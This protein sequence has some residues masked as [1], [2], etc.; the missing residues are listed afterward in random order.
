MTPNAEAA[1]K[2]RLEGNECFK[3]DRFHQA[4]EL[5]TKAIDITPTPNLLCN[6]SFAYIKVELPGAALMD[7]DE[8]IRLEPGFAKAYYRKASAHL[9]M[10]KFKEALADFEIVRK[11]VPTDEDA[12]KKWEECDKKVRQIRFEKA[13]KAKEGRPVSETI[14]IG[15]VASTYTGPRID[16]KAGITA[17]FVKEM[18]EHLRQEKKLDRH[19]VIYILLEVLKLF[20]AAPNVVDV[21]VP[22]DIRINV[23]GDTHGQFYDTLHIF[24]EC[25]EPSP[26]NWYLFNGDF[27]DRGSYSV[28]NALMLFAYKL[29]LPNCFFISRGNHESITMNRVYGFEGEVRAKYSTEVFD[30][31]LEVFNAL[32]FAH[33][34]NNEVFV[35]H[36]G[37]YSDDNITIADLQKPNRFRE[38]P[39]SGPIC[40]SLWADP[41]PMPGRTPS[42]RGVNCP[43]FGPDVTAR[44]LSHNNLKLV[45]RSHEV[46]DNGYEVEH[47]GKCITVF[48][49][50]NYCDQMKN[51]GAVI[52]FMGGSNLKPK[53]V[54]FSESPH[55]GKTMMYYASRG[56]GI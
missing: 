1:E 11:L 28:E 39:E 20:N 38:I 37:L 31:F 16:E 27:V 52:Q 42:K 49:A 25:G 8:A 22:D 26:L 41:Q 30:L 51:K 35:V 56:F 5:Y 6:R 50:P 46:K 12:K 44:F 34:I 32:P 43:A 7:A 54:V 33:V 48:S 17:E 2:F 10:G 9:L 55:P 15:V 29:L 45:I 24:E 53:Y 19:D 18:R 36:G 40:E 21:K 23:C 14:S 47:D 3:T 13:I 4:I